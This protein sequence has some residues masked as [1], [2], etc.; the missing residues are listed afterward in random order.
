MP[1]RNSSTSTS[2]P[3]AARSTGRAATRFL[4]KELQQIVRDAELGRRHVDKLACVTTHAGEEDWLCVH[5]EVQ[6]SVDH[7]LRAPDVRL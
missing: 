6:G 7:R 4:D 1:S 3:P 2:P 5:I